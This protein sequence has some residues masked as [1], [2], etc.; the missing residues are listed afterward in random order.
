[1]AIRNGAKRSGEFGLLQMISEVDIG[2]CGSQDV[3][4]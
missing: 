1:M 2:Q 3:G 4:P